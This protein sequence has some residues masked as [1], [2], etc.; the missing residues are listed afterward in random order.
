MASR[1]LKFVSSTAVVVAFAGAMVAVRVDN[2]HL[3]P[4][5]AWLKAQRLQAER[6]RDEN[7]QL[8]EIAARA[9]ADAGAGARAIRAD[10]ARART[11]VEELERKARA[12][13]GQLQTEA[14]LESENL[15]NNRDP[16]K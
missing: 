1:T 12:S 10:L 15:A 5:I 4:Q 14:V 7:R 3:R 2:A 13:H 6:L 16:E 11:E 9:Q 8:Q